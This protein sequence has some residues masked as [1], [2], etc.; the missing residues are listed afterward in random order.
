[1]SADELK[2][3]EQK[4]VH[5]D[6][7]WG[8]NAQSSSRETD[9]GN[10]PTELDRIEFDHIKKEKPKPP[11]PP[12]KTPLAV[13][14][15]AEK[16]SSGIWRL[17]QYRKMYFL[18][19]ATVV[20][21]LACSGV[22]WYM[23]KVS[24]SEPIS[25]TLSGDSIITLGPFVVASEKDKSKS[26][27]SFSVTVTV[28]EELFDFFQTQQPVVRGEIYQ[29]LKESEKGKDRCISKDRCILYE[30]MKRRINAKL[31][32]DIILAASATL[33]K[34]TAAPQ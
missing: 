25:R 11:P 2:S 17:F 23:A 3:P 31:G 28:A 1:M 20:A 32:R 18:V 4:L 30:Q 24:Q 6:F 33:E 14:P 27:L 29:V 26:F 19:G 16:P 22:V 5:D 8:G 21:L 7:D 34:S 9:S 15:V 12:P 10:Q 13:E